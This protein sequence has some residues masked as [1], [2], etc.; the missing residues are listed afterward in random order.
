MF[1]EIDGV[2]SHVSSVG[3]VE[4]ADEDVGDCADDLVLDGADE[5]GVLVPML[6]FKLEHARHVGIFERWG[7][8]TVDREDGERCLDPVVSS[9][10]LEFL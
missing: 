3:V 9:K 8:T 4:C 7:V 6:C 1:Q 10:V 2:A 5:V